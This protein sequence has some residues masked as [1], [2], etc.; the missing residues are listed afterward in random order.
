MKDLEKNLVALFLRTMQQEACW[1]LTMLTSNQIG[2]GNCLPHLAIN[3][4]ED[5]NFSGGVN[6]GRFCVQFAAHLIA[7]DEPYFIF[8]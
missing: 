8:Y 4:P 1:P 6:M 5:N 7:M 2:R 3:L